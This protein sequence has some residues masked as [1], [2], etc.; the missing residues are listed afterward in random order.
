[1]AEYNML[2]SA[3]CGCFQCHAADYEVYCRKPGQAIHHGYGFE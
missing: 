1:M 3:D 2:Y